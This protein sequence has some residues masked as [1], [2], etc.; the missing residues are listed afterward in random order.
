MQLLGLT[1]RASYLAGLELESLGPS[2]ANW[3]ELATQLGLKTLSFQEV[4]R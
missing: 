3:G 4:P 1:F 2:W